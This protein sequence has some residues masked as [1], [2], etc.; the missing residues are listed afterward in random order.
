[1]CLSGATPYVSYGKLAAGTL[2]GRY[3]SKEETHAY[4]DETGG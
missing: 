4:F 2:M 3:N 1:M